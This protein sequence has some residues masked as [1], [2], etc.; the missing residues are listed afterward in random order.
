ML[1]NIRISV[2]QGN[3]I[4]LSPKPI[5]ATVII[6][7]PEC[8]NSRP[9]NI[10]VNGVSTSR[11]T[12][13]DNGSLIVPANDIAVYGT[14]RCG[15]SSEQLTTYIICPLQPENGRRIM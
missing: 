8:N 2:S 1:L 12:L 7:C 13:L 14:L 3:E 4:K 10:I 15:G 6:D 9:C 5:E 11:Y